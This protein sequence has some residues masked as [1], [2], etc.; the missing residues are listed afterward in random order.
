MPKRPTFPP[1]T[2]RIIARR[3][4][5]DRP[6][7]VVISAG[8]WKAGEEWDDNPKVSSI[9]VPLDAD[10]HDYSLYP[11]DGLDALIVPAS[12]N[13]ESWTERLIM[14]AWSGEPRML[15]LQDGDIAF[16]LCRDMTYP[17]SE[18]DCSP[19]DDLATHIR[20]EVRGYKSVNRLLA[21]MGE[22]CWTLQGWFS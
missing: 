9:V 14:A 4:A 15:W 20:D 19:V 12:G 6:G 10:P 13:P 22:P 3:I 2:K 11:I 7:L 21:E 1:Y 5:N 18:M 16:R 17:I 8:S